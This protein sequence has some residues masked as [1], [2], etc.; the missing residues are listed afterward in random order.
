MGIRFIGRYIPNGRLRFRNP[1]KPPA[2]PKAP[3]WV[4][5]TG[6]IGAYGEG[7]AVDLELTCTDPDG[8]VQTYEVISGELPP[9]ISLNLFSG[10]LIGTV[11]S[12]E[13]DTNYTFTVLVT[14]KTGLTLQGTFSLSILNVASQVTWITPEGNIGE[15][16]VGD[17]YRNMVEATSK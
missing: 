2:D 11:G 15:P 4:I 6:H 13:E 10:R 17:S 8:D 16:A 12:V 5:N 14:D 7:D 9:G 3:Q 1:Y